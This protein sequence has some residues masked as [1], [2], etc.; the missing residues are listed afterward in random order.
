MA[1]MKA[2]QLEGFG[3]VDV[4]HV[5]RVPRP[6]PKTGEVLVAVEAAGINPG[7]TVI[8][9]GLM[10]ASLGRLG[11]LRRGGRRWRRRL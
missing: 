9:R 8:R 10:P 11:W 1:D 2:V 3:D 5:R 7:E 4:L 6:S